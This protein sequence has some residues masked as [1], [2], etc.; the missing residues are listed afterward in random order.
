M[1]KNSVSLAILLAFTLLISNPMPTKADQNNFFLSP[2]PQSGNVGSTTSIDLALDSFVN[3]NAYQF[4]LTWNQQVLTFKNITFVWLSTQAPTSHIIDLALTGNEL[5][6]FEYFTDP[7]MAVT[8]TNQVLATITWNIIAGGECVLSLTEHTYWQP[9]SVEI[10]TTAT[11]GYFLTRQPFVDFTWTPTAPRTGETITYDGTASRATEMAIG[12]V[13]KDG[14]VDSTDLGLMGAAWGTFAG[15]PNWNPACDL[16]PD[17]VVDSTDLGILGVRWGTFGN[18]ITSHNWWIDD[19]NA[20][21]GP[22]VNHSYASYSKTPHNITLLV[23]DSKGYSFGL[24]KSHLVDRDPAILNVWPSMEDYQGSIQFEFIAGKYVVVGVRVANTGTITEYTDNSKGDFPSTSKLGLYVIHSKGTPS[25]TEEEIGNRVGKQ[26]R[27]YW[28]SDDGSSIYRKYDW[29]SSV[30]SW[31]W[32][33][34]DLWGWAP[35]TDLYFKANFTDTAT[36]LDPFIGDTDLSNNELWFGP[37]NITAGFD[38]DIRIERVYDMDHGYYSPAQPFGT[39]FKFHYGGKF[40][41]PIT[42]ATGPFDPIGPGNVTDVYVDISNVGNND[43]TVTWYL[44]AGDTLL[45][46]ETDV[47]TKAV[48]YYSFTCSWD[49]TGFYGTYTLKVR[50][51]PVAGETVKWAT[52]DNNLANQ[53]IPY[54]NAYDDW[55]I[56]NTF[57]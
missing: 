38:H 53:T 45:H 35:E 13:N 56:Y 39:T 26:I 33:F 22:T 36:G 23:T 25:Q 34:L 44:Y 43:E 49:T 7:D 50:V 42:G 51:T 12:D 20:G 54:F 15:D 40:L 30:G 46:S 5:T 52:W 2:T 32:K 11:N 10:P 47:L 4:K 28:Y 27:R 24:T 14:A 29:A 17:G 31:Y 18:Y 9:G 19:I 48:G 57:P 37:F 55:G 3:L 16:M 1:N 6:A 8:S 21:T 41:N